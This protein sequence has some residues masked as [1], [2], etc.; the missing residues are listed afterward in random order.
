MFY[1]FGFYKFKKLSGLKKLRKSFQEKLVK[2]CVRGTII[3]SNEGIKASI[4]PL[5]SVDVVVARTN[6]FSDDSQA[7]K[8]TIPI[9]NR[10]IKKNLR[11]TLNKEN[12]RPNKH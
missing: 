7:A 1:I 12:I 3:F 11:F 10:G 8:Q 5:F 4:K 6:S 2:N 9:R